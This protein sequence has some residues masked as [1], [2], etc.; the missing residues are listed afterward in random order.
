[1]PQKTVVS[2][3]MQ[4]QQRGWYEQLW[5][6]VMCAIRCNWIY[7][8]QD[9]TSNSQLHLQI[10]PLLQHWWAAYL[11]DLD[12]TRNTHPSN[13]SKRCTHCLLI[14]FWVGLKLHREQIVVSI[15]GTHGWFPFAS[16]KAHVKICQSP[17]GWS[18]F[19]SAFHHI[20]IIHKY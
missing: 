4:I 7:V 14:R 5:T 8:W 12:I 1:M 6:Y 2:S 10:L 18:P 3:K 19:V 13:I 15:E 11:K 9:V 16:P 20:C 17:Y